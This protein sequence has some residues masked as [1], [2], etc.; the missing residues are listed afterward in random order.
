M[1]L[2]CK[3]M[4]LFCI[5][6]TNPD[7]K[8]ICFVLWLTNP[9]SQICQS[10]F[11]SPILKDSNRGFVLWPELPKIQPVFTNPTNPHESWQILSTIAWNESLRIQAG[12]FANPD[13]QIQTLKICIVDSFHRPVFQRFVLWICF[14]GLFSKDSFCGFVL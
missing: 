9:T 10:G 2:F 1:D 8:K 6:V 14:V 12:R 13:L 3:S 7:S 4:D 11:V 5:V